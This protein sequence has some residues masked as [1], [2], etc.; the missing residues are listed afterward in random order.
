MESEET[1]EVKAP[2]EVQNR[3]DFETEQDRADYGDDYEG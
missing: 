2:E 1:P 3:M